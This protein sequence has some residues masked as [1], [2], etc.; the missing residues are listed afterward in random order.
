MIDRD[1]HRARTLVV[2][3]HVR[4]A[5]LVCAQLRDLG[6]RHV[7]SVRHGAQARRLLEKQA[8][9]IIVCARDFDSTDDSA[10]DLLDALRRDALLPHHTVFLTL[11]SRATYHQ[12]MEAA[13]AA[14]DGILVRPCSTDLLGQR[15]RDARHRKRELGG[16]LHALDRGETDQALVQALRR[17]QEKRPFGIYCGRLAAE[18]L[19]AR[20]RPD[21]ALR[22]FEALA[23]QARKAPWARLGV[24]RAQLAADDSAAAQ[25]TLT[26]VLAED[27]RCADAHDLLGRLLADRGEWEAA[28]Q[29][30]RR[31]AE[32][33]PGCLLRAQQAGALAFHR[34]HH[35]EAECLLQNAFHMNRYSRFFE[36]STLLLLAILKHNHADAPG[37]KLMHEH[38]IKHRESNPDAPRLQRL[39]QGA[40]VLRHWQGG[41][42]GPALAALRGLSAQ[43][44]DDDFDLEAAGLVLALW[45]RLPPSLVPAGEADAV[46]DRI[47]ERF[48]VS[49]AV[50]ALL[51]A[52][53]GP[54]ST[55]AGRI[56]ACQ[57]QVLM[58]AERAIERAL[59]GDAVGAAHSL[60]AH[61]EH[62]LNGKL[63]QLASTIASRHG[64][65]AEGS[66]AVQEAARALE[67]R[68]CSKPVPIGSARRTSRAPGALP[69]RGRP[70][71]EIAH[72][73]G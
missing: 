72:A 59:A 15:L 63:L 28:W 46:T 41:A 3:S 25:Q 30:S 18:L 48:C 47:A 32:L 56:R 58:L 44:G 12:V 14:P 71:R 16:V 66:Q 65:H 37:V 40:A 11:A 23:A 67:H 53:A 38:L 34:G 73:A 50:T 54:D 2:D 33:T 1:I 8:F 17:Y 57:S 69:L 9:D 49:H 22:L 70:T 61:A 27:P 43:A 36:P 31:A 64:A 19:L 13:E 20:Q 29:A 55:A 5:S 24:A 7:V 45:A 35:T 39:E 6:V 42:V 60:L 4:M 26:E 10:Q 21:E 62:S 51:L 52:A 68:T